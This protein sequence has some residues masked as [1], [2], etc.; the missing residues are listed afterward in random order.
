MQTT[1]QPLPALFHRMRGEDAQA[2]LELL[3]VLFPV[4]GDSQFQEDSKHINTCTFPLKDLRPCYAEVSILSA[5]GGPV[6][7]AQVS[8]RLLMPAHKSGRLFVG[9]MSRSTTLA[10]LYDYFRRFGPELVECE[11]CLG[12]KTKQSRGFG[13]IKFHN[14]IVPPG[15]L[16]DDYLNCASSVNQISHIIDGQSVTVRLYEQR[17]E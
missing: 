8:K 14:G 2:L 6:G 9:G 10:T 17:G 1:E 13:F 15:V 3:S 5:L 7:G 16:S 4:K 11:I 12:T